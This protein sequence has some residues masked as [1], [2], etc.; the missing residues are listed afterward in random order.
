M[1]LPLVESSDALLQRKKRLID[2]C[3]VDSCLLAHIHMI[4]AALIACEVDKRDLS[5]QFFSIFKSDLENSMRARG[6]CVG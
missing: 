1:A 4:S 5:E 2:L 6:V 3:S